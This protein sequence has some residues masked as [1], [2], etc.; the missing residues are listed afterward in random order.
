MKNYN[1]KI[2]ILT[3]L[4]AGTI[5]SLFGTS[6]LAAA[7]LSFSFVGGTTYK[8]GDT[9]RTVI[10][11]SPTE[12]V[13]TVK[14]QFTYP[15]NL[16]KIES[17]TFNPKW[18]PL[19]QPGYDVVDNNTGL[20]IKTAG[21][22]AGSD[23]QIVLGTASFRVL[24]PGTAT[25]KFSSDSFVLN[26]NNTNV[27]GSLGSTDLTLASVSAPVPTPSAEEEKE[28]MVSEEGIPSE[29]ITSEEEVAVS[30]E[31]VEKVVT[32]LVA[33]INMIMNEIGQSIWKV[34]V[35]TLCFVVLVFIGIMEWN[36]IRKK[37][38]TIKLR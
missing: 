28:E 15:A 14:A 21:Y 26:A 31:V 11:I 7:D 8:V 13:Y 22:P 12:K 27:I 16:L 38:K 2:K 34:V 33:D 17:F 36:A 4:A 20:L 30:K 24:K 37:K 9:F 25:L 19:S 6:V 23:A 1:K 5:L 10:M 3:F 29:E 32:P 18:I 35:I